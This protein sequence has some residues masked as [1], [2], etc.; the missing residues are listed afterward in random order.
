MQKQPEAG[1]PVYFTVLPSKAGFTDQLFQFSTFYKL[2]LELGYSYRHS[3]VVNSR[4]GS[5][6][7]FDFLGFN[8]HFREKV[9]EREV[10][11]RRMGVNNRYMREQVSL[12]YGIRRKVRF[13]FHYLRYFRRFNFIDIGPG[14]TRPDDVEPDDLES[15]MDSVRR[16]V[17]RRYDAGGRRMNVVRFHL[18]E[19]GRYFFGQLAPLINQEIPYYQDRLD[20]R[21]T[22]FRLR[23]SQPVQSSFGEDRLNLLVHIRLGDTALIRTPWQ[24]Y[25][26][27]WSGWE[28][29][30]LKEYSDRQGEVFGQ[31]MDVDDYA[32]FL[33]HLN[34]YFDTSRQS[35]AVFSDGYDAGFKVLFRHIKDLGL[36]DRRIAELRDMQP[37]YESARFAL[38]DEFDNTTCRIGENITDLQELIHA[39]LTA[40]VIIVGCHQRMIPKF[41][42]TYYDISLE[43][44]PIIIVLYKSRL[45]EYEKVL[46]LDAKKAAV[47]QVN[48]SDERYSDA[49]YDAIA[50]IR[51][52]HGELAGEPLPLT[53]EAD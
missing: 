44:P 37:D 31:V 6:G 7:I 50:E 51:R 42:A 39:S 49:L 9:T 5:E 16:V 36:D 34:S 30:P 15:F 41:L 29:V 28:Q 11:Y 3:T 4:E 2:G 46:G 26:P 17:A 38:F 23:R 24:S 40:D 27:L 10:P 1:S 32:R 14:D 52:R 20:L 43:H 35:V 47:F 19:R 22:Y 12:L 53:R 13:W 18:C 8:E 21:E 25:I 48:F 33:A 45:P